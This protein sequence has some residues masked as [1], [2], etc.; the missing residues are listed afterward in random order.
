MDSKTNI[1]V[2]LQY[3]VYSS[4]YQRI[5]HDKFFMRQQKDKTKK[6]YQ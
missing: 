3:E 6:M 4:K 1:N 5:Y 2:E